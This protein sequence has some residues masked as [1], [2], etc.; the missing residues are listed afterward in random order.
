M[1]RYSD[2]CGFGFIEE[3]SLSQYMATG[4]LTIVNGHVRHAAEI[5]IFSPIENLSV[6]ILQYTLLHKTYSI[7]PTT[8]SRNGEDMS[9]G[10][11]VFNRQPYVLLLLSSIL[12]L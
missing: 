3:I 1:Y 2:N 8:I 6:K 10:V 9:D 7:N 4:G 11:T 5:S 12:G